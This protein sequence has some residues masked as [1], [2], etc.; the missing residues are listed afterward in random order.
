MGR[1]LHVPAAVGKACSFTFKELCGSAV[2]AADYIALAS[3]FH[4]VAVK[5]VP[6]VT[7]ENRSHAYRFVTLV[8]V[9]YEHRIKLLLSA[10]AYADDLFKNVRTGQEAAVEGPALPEC[11]VVDDNLGFAKHRTVSRLVEMQTM[12]YAITHAE[13]HAPELLLALQE[14]QAKA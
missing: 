4:T 3:H 6:V 14:A 5:G 7:A 8:D 9:L 13:R 11:A 10:E 1:T 2:A 12:E